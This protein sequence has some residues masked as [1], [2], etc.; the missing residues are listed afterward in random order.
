MLVPGAF[1]PLW[2]NR[3]PRISVTILHLKWADFKGVFNSMPGNKIH[4]T[5]SHK[6]HEISEIATKTWG[7]VHSVQYR[8]NLFAQVTVMVGI[9]PLP[10]SLTPSIPTLITLEGTHKLPRYL[11]LR[12]KTRGPIKAVPLWDKKAPL[13]SV[14]DLRSSNRHFRCIFSP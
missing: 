2:N 12:T 7:R 4:F 5:A 13:G 1:L 3:V 14:A 11:T 6:A 8:L 9:L 10:S